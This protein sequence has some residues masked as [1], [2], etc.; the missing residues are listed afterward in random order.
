VGDP[1]A[2]PPA[3]WPGVAVVM[4]VRNEASHLADAVH[5]IRAQD[6]PGP[7]TVC[8][9]LAPSTDGTEEIAARLARED[10]ALM[11]VE[12]PGGTT[13]AGL[14]AAIAATEEPIIVRVDGHSVLSP[15][16]I[17]RAVA[18][19]QSTGA[20]NVGGVQQ[21]IGT[22]PFERAVAA[23]MSSPFGT[24]DARFHY[25]G[26][27]GPTDTVYLGVFD[28]TAL[29]HAGGFDEDLVRNQDYELNI[30]LRQGGGVVWFDPQLAVGYRPRSSLGALARQYFEYG[31]W[32]REV[33]RR[34]PRSLRW[35]QAVPP[36]AVGAVLSGLIAGRWW[37]PAL[38]APAGYAMAVVVAALAAGQREPSITVRLLAV[39]PAMH[40]AWVTGLLV[41]PAAPII[42]RGGTRAATH[43]RASVTPRR[44][45]DGG[46]EGSR[47][48][49]RSRT[50]G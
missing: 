23:A 29:D 6:Y 33:L 45:Q 15:G 35:R 25:G 12:S 30:R 41:G 7:M 13:P 18:T 1:N 20:V 22:T 5:A 49:A 46:P 36:V 11:L 2:E 8:L 27:P 38:L 14:N 40:G 43:R 48:R 9:A 37:R 3:G 4:P 39:F 17:R 10:P 26:P 21:A 47:S 28:R 24:G 42:R 16:Y 44:H 19:L 50:L 34:H 32:K 31:Q